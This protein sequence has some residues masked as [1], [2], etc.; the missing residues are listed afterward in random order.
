[1]SS[2][3][4]KAEARRKA[5]L[6][7]GSDRLAKLTTSARGEDGSAYLDKPLFSNSARNFVGEETSMPTPPARLSP[8][9]APPSPQPHS[10]ASSGLDGSV[11]SEE[12][13]RQLFQALMGAGGGQDLPRGAGM[14]VGPQPG[15][16]PELPPELA[17]NP[18][19]AMLFSAANGG[20]MPPLPPSM[21]GKAPAS[22]QPQPQ[23]AKPKTTFQKLM[24]LVH[25]IA[26]WILLAYFVFMKEPEVQGEVSLLESRDGLTSIW[27]RWAELAFRD[28]KASVDSMG[29]KGWTVTVVPFFWAF[30]SLQ[31]GLHSTRIF[32][33]FDNP[34]L[35]TLLAM[36]LP[37]IPPPFPSIIVNGLKYLQMGSIL[38]DDLAILTVGTGLIIWVAG[39]FIG[40]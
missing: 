11:W 6:S 7:R 32:Y 9:P 10:D 3:A 20:T 1:M 13:Q 39:L 16:A 28:P 33:G 29:A 30:M 23:V 5:I 36:A 40:S 26:I 15:A 34:Q 22:Q 24:P 27:R 35:P 37:H 19:A 2:A 31:I 18:L 17:N 4:A 21:L 25:L 8:S 38:L 12:Q 14:G